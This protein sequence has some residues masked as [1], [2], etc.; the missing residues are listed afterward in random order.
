MASVL[1]RLHDSR[2][3]ACHRSRWHAGLAVA[4]LMIAGARV[5]P[6]Q[7]PPWTP[8]G[9]AV[10]VRDAFVPD[11]HGLPDAHA[12]V[13][14]GPANVAAVFLETGELRAF[15]RDGSSHGTVAM[16]ALASGLHMVPAGVVQD[17]DRAFVFD[18][19]H[20][21]LSRLSVTAGQVVA[22]APVTLD[23]PPSIIDVCISREA[24][25]AYAAD[26]GGILYRLDASGKRVAAMQIPSAPPR[27]RFEIWKD[28][29]R[30]MCDAASR[31]IIVVN[32]QTPLVRAFGPDGRLR[33]SDSLRNY[34]HTRFELVGK[35]AAKMG[36]PD[37]GR[38]GLVSLAMPGRGLLM[39]QLGLTTKESLTRNT[40]ASLRTY[41]LRAA[42]GK[43]VGQ[44]DNQAWIAS[45]TPRLT[46]VRENNGL[47]LLTPTPAERRGTP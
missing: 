18:L 13:S 39:V 28:E 30:L 40:F 9:K 36:I 17:G 24:V 21:A 35:T 22:S 26:S 2:D 45:A 29:A 16:P 20:T 23:V 42:D 46:V 12:V 33:W 14:V 7:A 5:A 3:T 43:A 10:P 15:G 44:Y 32:N 11:Y 34:R 41:Y 31:L 27:S 37:S 4:T 6:A 1:E 38:H 8:T 19:I 25:F 47:Q